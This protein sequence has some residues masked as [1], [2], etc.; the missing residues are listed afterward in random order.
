MAFACA[1]ARFSSL[2]S[3]SFF[4]SACWFLRQ[5]HRRNA[6]MHTHK[7]RA[8]SM[9]IECVFVSFL[10]VHFRA[11]QEKMWRRKETTPFLSLSLF[12]RTRLARRG[13][14]ENN[15][16]C[17][18]T[19]RKTKSTA[20]ALRNWLIARCLTEEKNEYRRSW[21]VKFCCS[22]LL[23]FGNKKGLTD[24]GFCC[25][26]FFCINRTREAKR[27]DRNTARP[28]RPTHRARLNR[29]QFGKT[30][31]WSQRHQICWDPLLSFDSMRLFCCS[32]KG[33]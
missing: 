32:K 12:S 25:F 5:A 19:K 15:A 31:R 10:S 17:L 14:K 9:N 27:K 7:I 13:W 20:T 3:S 28:L 24:H 11:R 4:A 18:R 1:R 26:C 8:G 2:L 33:K 30:R 16:R 22:S 23:A 6:N 29:S 21:E